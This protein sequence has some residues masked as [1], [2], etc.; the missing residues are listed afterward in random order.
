M[1][2]K[3]VEAKKQPQKINDIPFKQLWAKFPQV[4]GT[5]WG[6]R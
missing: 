1:G 5:R 4:I 2:H 6:I 3:A